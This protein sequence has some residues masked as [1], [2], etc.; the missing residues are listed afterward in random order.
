MEKFLIFID[1]ADDAAMYPVSRL[2]AVTCAGDGAVPQWHIGCIDG[3]CEVSLHWVAPQRLRSAGC[4][5]S[6]RVIAH[7]AVRRGAP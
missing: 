3:K 4:A 6:Q 5:V 1:A 2:V 7:E